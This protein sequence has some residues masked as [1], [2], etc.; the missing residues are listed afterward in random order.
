[1]KGMMFDGFKG[2]VPFFTHEK[3]GY[4]KLGHLGGIFV[5]LRLRGILE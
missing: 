4:A 2:A 1:M 3:V 5:T